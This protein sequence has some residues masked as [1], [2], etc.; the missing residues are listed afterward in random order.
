[1]R[2]INVDYL[3]TIS[4]IRKNPLFLP[5]QSCLFRFGFLGGGNYEIFR[6]ATGRESVRQKILF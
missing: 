2:M 3:L 4:R 1:M 5:L 6:S